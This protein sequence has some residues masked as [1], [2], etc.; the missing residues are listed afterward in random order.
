[1]GSG[2][3]LLLLLLLLLLFLLLLLLLGCWPGRALHLGQGGSM[4]LHMAWCRGGLRRPRS[5][6]YGLK[7][8][9]ARPHLTIL[10]LLLAE[11]C[12]EAG[13]LML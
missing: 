13:D 7:D 10:G 2:S 6:R 8:R 12:G 3:W 1:L 4:L 9:E 5:R 11:R